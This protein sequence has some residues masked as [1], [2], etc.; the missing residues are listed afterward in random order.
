MELLYL[1]ASLQILS[2]LVSL[3]APLQAP[4][5]IMDPQ[6]PVYFPGERLTLRCSAPS[7]EAVTSYQFY[8]QRGEWVFTETTGLLGGPWLV[9]TAETGK[10]GEYS[11]EYWA[12]RDGRHI[13]SARSQPVLVPVMDFPVAPSISVISDPPGKS[14]VTILCS[15]P[16][17]HVATRYQFLRQGNV[18][19]SQPDAHLQLHQSDLDATGSYTCSYEISVSGRAIQS[20]P[21]A[22][23]S[24]HPTGPSV[25]PESFRPMLRLSPTGPEFTTGESVTLTCSAPSWEKNTQFCFLKAGEQV[26]CTRQALEDSHSYQIGRLGMEDSGSYTCTYRVAEP[27]Q[28]ISLESQPISIRVTAPPLAPKLSLHPKLPVYL[29]GEKVNLNCSAPHG[30]EVVGFR[31]HQHRGDQTPEELPA[32]SEGPWMDLTAQTGNDGSYTC[33]YWRWEAGQEIVSENSNSITVPVSDSLPQP[34]LIV[35]PPSG[36]VNEGLPLLITCMTPGD[37]GAWRFHFYKDGTEIVPGDK[38]SDISTTES[39]SGS[40]NI[41]VLSIPQYGPNNTGE[42]TCGYEKNMSGRWIQSPRSQAVTVTWNVTR[43]YSWRGE[44]PNSINRMRRNISSEVQFPSWTHRWQDHVVYLACRNS[45]LKG[46]GADCPCSAGCLRYS[47]VH[48][49]MQEKRLH[50]RSWHNAYCHSSPV[51]QAGWALPLPLVAGCGGGG[52]A[53]GLLA[54]LGCCCRRKK[55]GSSK[56][57]TGYLG[58][59]GAPGVHLAL[60]QRSHDGCD[61]LVTHNQ[62]RL[63]SI[64]GGKSKNRGKGQEDAGTRGGCP[65]LYAVATC[66][67]VSRGNSTFHQRGGNLVSEEVVYSEPL[68]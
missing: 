62:R 61:Q 38:G 25:L 39:V 56:T 55:K 37:L 32:A 13:Y 53:L 64:P 66:P 2:R 22:P 23:L 40:V 58:V 11:C 67:P 7:W 1:L 27:G 24:L 34:L 20:L 68:F 28:E 54:L 65:T 8:N 49:A 5:I 51:S 30:E 43:N 10:A 44:A 48:N 36:V 60:Q 45:F 31:F 52:A 42:F 47:G 26:A 29:P 18:F 3:A 17:G 50:W 4:T 14:P 15:A 35:D 57:A 41:S 6:H 19:V 59:S 16:L 46:E 12:V 21:S 9:L 33:Q 63:P